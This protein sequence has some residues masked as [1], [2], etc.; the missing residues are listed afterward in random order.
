MTDD[1]NEV[2]QECT[3]DRLAEMSIK[4]L[5]AK[6][7]VINIVIS[8][9]QHDGDERW[10]RLVPQQRLLNDEVHKRLREER[11]ARG[12]PKPPAQ[13]VALNSIETNVHRSGLNTGVGAQLVHISVLNLSGTVT[14]S[15]LCG[16]TVE[17]V[18]TTPIRA[19]QCPTCKLTFT[20]MCQI[21]VNR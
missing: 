20:P 1:L 17:A 15:C 19:T 21:A 10:R 18:L 2:L 12:E 7:N 8:Q 16:A 13:A 11:A 5:M 3:A 4:E 9:A 6:A 14:I